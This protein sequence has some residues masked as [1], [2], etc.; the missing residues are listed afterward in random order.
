MSDDARAKAAIRDIWA[1]GS[2]DQKGPDLGARLLEAGEIRRDQLDEAM[3]VIKHAPGRRLESILVDMGVDEIRVQEAAAEVAG[4][5][6]E[7]VA[8]DAI[9]HDAFDRLGAMYCQERSL[10]PLRME[11]DRLVVG[12]TMAHEAHLIDEVRS[13]LSVASVKHV[14]VTSSDV[15]AAVDHIRAQQCADDDVE[16][17]LADV[18]DEGVSVLDTP[19]EEEDEDADASPVVRFVNHII[20]TAVRDGASDIHIEPC[21]GDSRVRFRIDGVLYD[22]LSPPRRMHASITSRMKIMASLDIAERRLPQDGRI[23]VSVLGRTLDL[24]VSTCPTPH[25]E[26]TVLRILDNKAIQVPL[27]DLGFDDAV[28]AGWRAEVARSSGII[29]VTGPTGSGKT[30]TLYASLQEL[31]LGRSNVSTVEDP[32]EYRIGGITQIQTHERIGMT[33]AAALRALLRQDPD[34][35]MVGEIRDSETATIATQAAL[36]GHLVLSTLHTNDAP[37]SVTRLINI[38]IEPYLVSGAVN[39]VLAQRLVRK[40][41]PA[42]TTSVEVPEDAAVALSTCDLE[43]KRIAQGAGCDACRNSGY[44]GRMGIHELLV[45]DDTLRDAIASN[46]AVAEFRQRCIASGM[47][48]LRMDAIAKMAR[49][50]TSWQEVLRVTDA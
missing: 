36:T 4:M 45:P 25:G 11:S 35:V 12:T 21:D 20:Q 13:L 39:G 27:G 40:I 42:C 15:Q 34:V 2:E 46:P 1:P 38:G 29:L 50:Q 16:A 32:I 30:T 5:S 44:S 17:I 18:E 14:L 28:L 8:P 47:A 3:R 9:D 10:L 33:F 49:G 37:S 48:T 19:S 23:R 22:A 41:C 43:P 7:R 31:D 6:F 24:R 26:K